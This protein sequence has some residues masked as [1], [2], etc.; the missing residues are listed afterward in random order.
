MFAPGTSLEQF[1]HNIT[2]LPQRAAQIA[3][4]VQ[5]QTSANRRLAA[6]AENANNVA[7]VTMNKW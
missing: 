3:Q 4:E 7:A 2:D 5:M 6:M 1:A